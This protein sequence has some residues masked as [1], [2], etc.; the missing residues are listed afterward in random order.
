MHRAYKVRDAIDCVHRAILFQRH[1]RPIEVNGC[2]Y[3]IKKV[4][5]KSGSAATKRLKKKNRESIEKFQ[6][7]SRWRGEYQNKRRQVVHAA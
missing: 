3:H 4:G 7:M 1:E 2:D 6:N 5:A